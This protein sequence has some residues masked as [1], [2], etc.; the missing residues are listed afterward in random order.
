MDPYNVV[1][2]DHVAEGKKVGRYLLERGHERIA[3]MTQHPS[4]KRANKMRLQGLQEATSEAGFP[5]DEERVEM[6]ESGSPVYQA[7]QRIVESGA[8]SIY[9][10]GHSRYAIETM[11]I[12]QTI[13]NIKVPKQISVIGE[14][15]PWWALIASPP[16]TAVSVPYE[17]IAVQAVD[18]MQNLIAEGKRSDPVKKVLD[19]SII[20]RKSVCN[21]R[22]S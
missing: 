14:E 11:N 20:E 12:L 4:N 17:K 10:P 9:I 6:L 22:G 15:N 7:L 3:F 8:D 2:W 18:L 19:V 13:M 5:I 16:L 21:R 1:G